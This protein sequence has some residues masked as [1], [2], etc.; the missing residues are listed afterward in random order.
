MSRENVELS[1]KAIGEYLES[2]GH[3]DELYRRAQLGLEYLKAESAIRQVEVYIES[4][5]RPTVG[6]V[7][8]R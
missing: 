3:S 7:P 2:Q 5:P 8:P 6:V 4:M 1:E